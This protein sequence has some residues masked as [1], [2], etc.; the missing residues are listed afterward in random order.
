MNTTQNDWNDQKDEAAGRSLANQDHDLKHARDRRD[1]DMENENANRENQAA[2]TIEDLEEKDDQALL[3]EN[4]GS[5]EEDTKD[6]NDEN[7]D[8]GE[9]TDSE[10]NRPAQDRDENPEE[11]E[12]DVP[13]PQSHSSG[14]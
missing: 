2:N 12:A 5:E 10:G 3:S 6:E 13:S 14:L 8:L 1:G 7:D 9:Q 11:D 4:E